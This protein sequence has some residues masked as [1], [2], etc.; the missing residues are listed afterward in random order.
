MKKKLLL[1]C[2]GIVAAPMQQQKSCCQSILQ[3]AALFLATSCNIA[4]MLPQQNKMLQ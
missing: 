4:A 2:C 1:H 3:L